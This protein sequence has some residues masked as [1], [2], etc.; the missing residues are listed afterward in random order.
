MK[1]YLLSLL[2]LLL[3]SNSSNGQSKYIVENPDL[4]TGYNSFAFNLNETLLKQRLTEATAERNRNG[5]SSMTINLPLENGEMVTLDAVESPI[6]AKELSAKYPEIKTYKVEGDE[7][8]GRIGFTYKG[9]HAILF[10]KD[11]TVY[12]D[13]IGN[14]EN[15][16]HSYNRKDFTSFY[17]GTKNHQCDVDDNFHSFSD[18]NIP[19][20]NRGGKRSGEQL[21]TYRMA[22]ACTG[23]YG[24]FH[25][26]TVPG[27]L[28]AMIVTM[29]RVNGIYERDFAITMELVADNDL[30]IFLNPSSDPYSNTSGDLNA[31]QNTIT[32]IIGSNN[33]DIGHL[34]GTGGGG[35]AQL[36][37]VCSSS[38]KARGLTG[39]NS[40][41]GDP[42]D[43]DFVAHEFGHQFGANH[44]QNNNCARVA[45][46][47]Y[48]PGS[49]STIMG[50]AG[51]CSPNI[52]N[53]S[54][55]YFHAGSYNEVLDFAYS[56]NGNSC[57]VKTATGNT[58]PEVTVPSGG[59]FIPKETPFVLRGSATDVDNDNLTYCWEQMDLGPSSSPNNP[60]GNAPIFRSWTPE[61]VSERTCP[62]LL[63][64]ILGTSVVGE[65][66]PTY[67]RDLTFRL[68]VRDN[69]IAGGGQNFDEVAFEVDGDKG[70]FEVLSPTAGES[71][72]AFSSYEV[73]W[74][75]AQTDQAPISCQ[76]VNIYLCTNNGLIISDTLATNVPNTGNY[77]V[78][79]A[80]NIGFQRRIRVEAADNIFFNI[81]DGNFQIAEPTALEEIET[82]LTVDPNYIIGALELNWTDNF[83]NEA[84]WLIERSLAGNSN[85]VFIDSVPGNTVF[86]SDVNV[87]MYGEEYVYRVRA[88]NIIGQA[89]Y[90]NEASYNGLGLSDYKSSTIRLFPNPASNYVNIISD[91][92]VKIKSIE[93]TN[94]LG[95]LV[96]SVHQNVN[97]VDLSELSTGL[98]FVKVETQ[99]SKV[100]VMP[101]T[102]SAK[103]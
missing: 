80:D 90:S 49:A 18:N 70:P 27:A 37:S 76:S 24:Q 15:S 13:Q 26:G 6:M 1:Y 65:T 98:Y 87:D 38:G 34:V 83:D 57:A 71:I 42:F 35:V 85:F 53:F 47:A 32:N 102:V 96:K 101:F 55:D 52:Q 62:R 79:M 51:I 56:G 88:G 23:E 33:Y 84:Y 16:Y 9:F 41:V 44:T 39:G 11:G 7:V 95:A 78:Q 14:E 46:V 73:T 97:R 25:G 28:S 60:V 103:Q 21:R 19:T 5:A 99:D 29:N 36:G 22:L 54:D 30:L 64:V 58:A 81:N 86:Y 8:Q 43:I 61:D 69:N 63:N 10:T 2:T 59:F 75:V 100:S 20:S 4:K 68:S 45:S 3:V 72:E 89:D 31:N 74:D 93:V 91:E 67:S 17:R 48:E 92:N 12:I 82:T 50:Y 77:I 94:S 66:Y 40:P